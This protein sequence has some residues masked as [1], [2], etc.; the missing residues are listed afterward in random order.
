M[1]TGAQCACVCVCVRGCVRRQTHFEH[2]W[3]YISEISPTQNTFCLKCFPGV[4][5]FDLLIGINILYVRL[6]RKW[7]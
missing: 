5:V 4:Y 6:V 2:M 1:T 7:L 3:G